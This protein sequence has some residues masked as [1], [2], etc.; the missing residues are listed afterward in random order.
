[1]TKCPSLVKPIAQL[2]SAV[3]KITNNSLQVAGVQSA[4]IN[5]EIKKRK[6]KISNRIIVREYSNESFESESD[7]SDVDNSKVEILAI[8][9]QSGLSLSEFKEG[10]LV[11]HR[12]RVRQLLTPVVGNSLRDI[13]PSSIIKHKIT[14]KDP[15]S[16]PIK[17]KMRRIPHSKSKQFQDLINEMLEAG[18]IQPSNSPWCFPVRLVAKSDGKLRLTVDYIWLNDIT[19]KDSYPLRNIDD[20]YVRLAMS[21]VYS[22][23]DLLSGF[24]HVFLDENSRL[25]TAFATEWGLFEYRVMPMGLSNSPATFQRFM[26]TVFKDLIAE[27]IVLVFIDDILIYSKSIE[28]H[29]KD[30]QRVVEVLVKHNLKVKLSKCELFKTEIDFLGFR[31]VQ[32]T[33]KPSPAKVEILF[34]YEKPITIAQLQGFIGL[35]SYY[36]RFIAGFSKICSPLY[37]IVKAI[38]VDYNTTKFWPAWKK[39]AFSP[40][41]PYWNEVCEQAFSYLRTCLTTSPILILP[42][43]N[44]D[45]ILDTDACDYAVGAVLSQERAGHVLPVEYF[46]KSLDLN[47]RKYHISEKELMAIVFSIEHFKQYLYGSKFLVNTDHQALIHI[48]R[49]KKNHPR[50][51]RW[52]LELQNYDF[53]IKY[54]EGKKHTNADGLSRWLLE[55][56]EPEAKDEHEELRVLSINAIESENSEDNCGWSSDSGSVEENEGFSSDDEV[57]DSELDESVR[58][59]PNELVESSLNVQEFDADISWI[60]SLILNHQDVKPKQVEFGNDIRQKFFSQYDRLRIVNDVLYRY[61]EDKNGDLKQ[62]LVISVEMAT[63]ISKHIHSSKF[64]GHLGF[65]KTINKVLDRF[66]R[67]ALNLIVKDVLKNCKV[68]QKVKN[69]PHPAKAPLKPLIVVEPLELV[70]LDLVK[71]QH[72]SKQG[73]L[74]ILVISDHFTKFVQFHAVKDTSAIETGRKLYKFICCYGIPERILSDQGTNFE[75]DLLKYVWELLDIKKLRTSPYHPQTDGL[76]ERNIESLIGMLRAFSNTKQNNWESYLESLSFAYNTAVHATTNQTPYFLMFGHRPKI[77]IDLVFANN[78]E[79]ITEEDVLEFSMTKDQFVQMLDKNFILPEKNDSVDVSVQIASEYARQLSERLRF[80]YARINRNKALKLDKYKLNY[81]RK[82]RPF[83]YEIGDLVL[84][85]KPARTRE[86]RYRKLGIKFDGP[87]KVLK[88]ID[89][90]NYLIKRDRPGSR[91]QVIH[92]NRLKKFYQFGSRDQK[93]ECKSSSTESSSSDDNV[94][95]KDGLNKKEAELIK[96]KSRGRPKKVY[97][98][99]KTGSYGKM[100]ACDNQDCLEPNEWYHYHCVQVEEDKVPAKWLCPL[101]KS[102]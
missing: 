66:Y 5:R 96:K 88:V 48:H 24:Y 63:V 33:I 27:G 67:P 86:G 87:Y 44:K 71:M 68:C 65:R 95:A 55:D 75:S 2:R 78:K 50:L 45:Y 14:L 21:M 51:Q 73:N 13:Q 93:A 41:L 43:I 29:Y 40:K 49:T 60:K 102:K 62:Q 8:E 38:P 1:M 77:P 97:C 20:L 28:Q 11:K 6:V 54:K 90:L 12:E 76:S 98:V 99:C 17:Q 84:K 72:K 80:V 22:K 101:C 83:H 47:Q 19:I 4:V 36:R 53:Q 31:V 26:D 85:D 70:T 16:N 25:F 35:A 100:I 52:L 10:E 23:F 30:I 82:I 57:E 91:K 7:K 18:L 9:N 64:N 46:S 56:E 92:H 39:K 69:L 15:F 32:G 74:Y 89:P 58:D 3:D 94:D 42:D 37:D 59:E 34:K 61:K 79:L 81:D